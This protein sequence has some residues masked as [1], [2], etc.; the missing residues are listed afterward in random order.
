MWESVQVAL[1]GAWY[2]LVARFPLPA[3][4]RWEGLNDLMAHI[5]QTGLEEE[6]SETA[7]TALDTSLEKACAQWMWGRSGWL[8]SSAAPTSAVADLFVGAFKTLNM[9]TRVQVDGAT[10]KATTF[11]CPFIEH[12]RRGEATAQRL[13]QRICS[14]NHSLFRGFVQ[15]LPFPVR[16]EAPL[17]RGWG[18]DCCAKVF[19]LPTF[20]DQ[21]PPWAACKEVGWRTDKKREGPATMGVMSGTQRKAL[22]AHRPLGRFA[23]RER[24][25]WPGSV[26]RRALLHGKVRRGK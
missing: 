17:K 6:P 19:R 20:A 14:T 10:I 24:M 8:T 15:G 26:F 4:D 13:C 12:T 9:A 5:L 3:A 2:R 18:D 1:I 25:P 21:K 22:E 23:D 11:F 16:Y 7:G